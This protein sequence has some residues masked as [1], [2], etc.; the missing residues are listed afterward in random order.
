MIHN[1][2]RKFTMTGLRSIGCL[3]KLL[4]ELTS[5]I[6][7][8]I[9]QSLKALDETFQDFSSCLR[10]EVIQVGENS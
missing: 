6:V 9:L 3:A 10:F 5:R 8:P 4:S 2:R 1:N 7:A